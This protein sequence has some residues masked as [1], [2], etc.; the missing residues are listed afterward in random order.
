MKKNKKYLWPNLLF[1][2]V[3]LFLIPQSRVF[4]ATYYLDANNG[5]DSNLGTSSQP[6]KTLSK[7][8]SIVISGDTVIVR[9]GSYGEYMVFMDGVIG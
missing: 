3:I 4:A 2:V 7:A 9:D 6:W 5:N 1:L 8:Q